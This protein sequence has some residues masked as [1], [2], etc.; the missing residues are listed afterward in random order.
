MASRSGE[1]R[2]G[3]RSPSVCCTDLPDLLGAADAEPDFLQN[4]RPLT[5]WE[6]D[7]DKPS[8]DAAS[9]AGVGAVAEGRAHGMS[10]LLRR[11]RDG[12]EL[13][14][15]LVCG[16]LLPDVSRGFQRGR[17]GLD[18]PGVWGADGL[19]E[20]AG[21]L[22]GRGAVHRA[23][24]GGVLGELLHAAGAAGGDDGMNDVLIVGMIVG[25]ILIVVLLIGLA[26]TAG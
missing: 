12:G 6:T 10:I 13:P 24:R 18:M 21:G 14:V 3:L 15:L 4:G 22:A 17:Q 11:G 25:T 19:E 20:S 1:A 16:V 9:A 5:R 8:A 26:L 23:A 2:M 7:G